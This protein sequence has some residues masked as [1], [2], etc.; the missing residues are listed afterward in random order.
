VALQAGRFAR[1]ADFFSIGTNDLT[2]YVLAV[3]RGNDLVGRRYDA[4]HPAVLDLV[5]RTVEAGR[6]AGIPVTL[7]GELASDPVATPLLLGL[8]LRSLSASPTYLPAVKRMVRRTPLDAARALAA[9]ARGA[10]DAAAVRRH[11]QAWIGDRIDDPPFDAASAS[12][13]S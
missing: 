2:Q 1:E 7:C 12:G 9:E 11:A 3:D 4:L 13:R 5:A 6:E 10:P 8:G